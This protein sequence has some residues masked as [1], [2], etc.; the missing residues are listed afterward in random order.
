MALL[1]SLERIPEMQKDMEDL[2]EPSLSLRMKLENAI[3][4]VY[5]NVTQEQ[6]QVNNDKNKEENHNITRR[7][8][9]SI[10]KEMK[11]VKVGSA[12]QFSKN[13]KYKF[14]LWRCWF[15]QSQKDQ[16]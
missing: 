16:Q 2:Q 1:N 11:E 3:T 14:A 6:G 4:Q 13:T 8:K 15:N 12:Y 7:P 10:R 9:E 5:K